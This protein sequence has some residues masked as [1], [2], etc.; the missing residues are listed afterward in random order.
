MDILVRVPL[1]ERK[2]YHWQMASDSRAEPAMLTAKTHHKSVR[3]FAQFPCPNSYVYVHDRMLFRK[4]PYL[5]SRFA[6]S[7]RT[8]IV[9]ASERVRCRKT[10][11]GGMKVW[12]IRVQDWNNAVRSG[13]DQ[14]RCALETRLC[15]DVASIVMEYVK[16]EEQ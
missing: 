1:L 8:G 3:V 5:V 10:R 6:W 14:M 16:S 7:P 12:S 4:G 11:T 13:A 2:S 15:G 9:N